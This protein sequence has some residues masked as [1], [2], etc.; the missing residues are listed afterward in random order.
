MKEKKGLDSSEIMVKKS[1]TGFMWA[2]MELLGRQGASLIIQVV[3][4][5]LL[6]PKDFGLIGMLAIFMALATT[7]IDSGFQN[8]LLQKKKPTEVDYSTVYLFNILSS[9]A[10]YFIL[11]LSSSS[12]AKFYNEPLLEQLIKVLGLTLIFAALSMVHR[13]QL[14]RKMDFKT[15]A[16][17]ATAAM[18]L[19][20]IVAIII[21]YLG[22]GV[23]SLVI[24]QI[25]N[26]LLQSILLILANRWMPQLIF[27]RTSF[28]QMFHYGWKILLSSI[29]DTAYSNGTSVFIGKLFSTNLLG[30]Y[31]N[32]RK[33]SDVASLSMAGTVQKVSFPM[34]SQLKE[35]PIQMRASF[36]KVLKMVSFISFPFML[37]LSATGT[38][39]IVF[40]FG[41]KWIDA[42]P[43]FRIL[44]IAAMFMPMHILNIILLQI[45][46]RTDRYLKLEIIKKVIALGALILVL[47]TFKNVIIL[48]WT[49]AI[50][51]TLA[52]IL[53]AY[54]TREIINYPL[55]AQL[56]DVFSYMFA[57]ILMFF[58]LLFIG[59][60]LKVRLIYMLLIKIMIGMVSYFLFVS[61]LKKETRHFLLLSI[62][63]K[64]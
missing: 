29:L 6:L 48:V 2:G 24:Q 15:Q 61:L 45:V 27:D 31:T 35:D 55:S 5:R 53:N 19:S 9:L 3:L 43:Y 46:E 42:V 25:L 34:L 10:L 22:F 28:R 37:G 12:I 32:A 21:A 51:G 59:Q 16:V 1:I 4:A 8:W 40:L 54:Y 62:K 14:S 23:W 33:I 64:N 41:E 44:C 36:K 50:V 13:V 52:L 18:L 63:Q 20:G 39:I 11:F 17:I 26:Q 30:Y 47:I 56:K 58:L 7:I 57:A 49:D 38:E 60:I